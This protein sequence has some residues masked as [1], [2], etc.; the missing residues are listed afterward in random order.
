M[1]PP[2]VISKVYF[3]YYFAGSTTYVTH[4]AFSKEIKVTNQKLDEVIS[5]LTTVFVSTC[6]HAAA[7]KETA[8]TNIPILPLDSK[9]DVD[10]L[11]TF[12]TDREENK[13]VMVSSVQS[14]VHYS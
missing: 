5:M 10:R 8:R 7:S 13:L 3:N 6:P 2:T 11:E 9:D 4:A 1:P 14:I 12:V